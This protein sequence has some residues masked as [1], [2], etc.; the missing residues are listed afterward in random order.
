MD[1]SAIEAGSFRDPSG[2][3]FRTSGVLYRQ[4]NERYRAQYDHLMGSGLYDELVKRGLLIPHTECDLPPP[5]PTTCYKVIKPEEVPFISYPHE[6]C[7]SQ[8][9]DAAAVTMQVQKTAMRYKMTLKDASAYNVAFHQ[10]RPL[11]I[12]TLSFD[13]YH[14]GT[15]WLPYR[16]FCQHFLAPL[17]L[18]QYTDIRLSQLFRVYIDGVPLDLASTL[19]PWKTRLSTG[20]LMHIHLHARS[21]R[22][23]GGDVLEKHQVMVKERSL[24]GLLD[25]LEGT[26]RRLTL[27]ERASEWTR[28][29]GVEHNYTPA[30]LTH[31][32]SVVRAMLEEA[33]PS[34][35]WDLGANTGRFSRISA[36]MGVPTV[37]FEI[38]PLCV[39]EM[40]NEAVARRDHNLF[41]LVID[42]GNPSPGIGWEN[43]ERKSFIS[44]GPTDTVLA[45]ALVHHLALVNNLPLDRIAAFF[46]DLCRTLIIEFV[47][48]QDSQVRRMVQLREDIFTSYTQDAFEVAFSHHFITERSEGVVDSERRVYLMRRR[49]TL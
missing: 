22:K 18:M 38:D 6:W 9:K 3:V 21:E 28:Y 16:Q 12:D 46:A 23:H 41:P 36:D 31:K 8:L 11:V 2:F 14:E 26:I 47:P 10:G 48:P 33:G 43:C 29:Y 1:T 42:L 4:V 5:S 32:E 44:R 20:L 40:Y 17:A 7:F 19:L 25:H 39:E 30:G 13:L 27:G 49:G 37:A 34:E 24:L 45:L 35:V 15:P